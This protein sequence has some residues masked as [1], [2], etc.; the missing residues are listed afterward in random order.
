ML[1]GS[2]AV[3]SLV[4][5][6]S[7]SADIALSLRKVSASAPH[8]PL[9]TLQLDRMV[10]ADMVEPKRDPFAGRSWYVPPPPPSLPPVVTGLQE[11]AAA[12]SV[13]GL[14]FSYMGRIQE[15][16]ERAVVYL[17]QGSQVYSV[18][19]GERIDDS[20]QLKKITSSQLVFVYLP[21]NV[22]QTLEV[23]GA[24]SQEPEEMAS[25]AETDNHALVDS[26]SQVAAAR[27]GIE[28]GAQ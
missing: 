10:R 7:S 1:T 23:G 27:Q 6:E 11:V 3:A 15:E 8:T 26:S 28:S 25:S 5:G 19:E 4:Q 12:P 22:K 13:P 17:T 14:P 9:P 2:L 21:L 18:S 24:F 16:G 20:Y